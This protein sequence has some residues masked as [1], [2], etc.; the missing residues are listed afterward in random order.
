[1]PLRTRDHQYA[2]LKG[3]TGHYT[4]LDADVT[5]GLIVADC[6]QGNSPQ[7]LQAFGQ[8]FAAKGDRRI[9]FYTLL[10]AA[11]L[12]IQRDHPYRWHTTGDVKF[13]VLTDHP[14]N[15]LA[16]YLAH[17]NDALQSGHNK[18]MAP[19]PGRKDSF[20][21]R[22]AEFYDLYTGWTHGRQPQRE[23]TLTYIKNTP[24]ALHAWILLDV[25]Q[26][27]G[28]GNDVE[29]HRIAADV[30][31]RFGDQIGLVYASRYEHARSL[32]QA[33]ER[34]KAKKLFRE[35][36]A[37]ALKTGGL[38]L[39]D[40]HFSD[41]FRG[42]QASS[43]FADQM[44]QTC[45]DLLKRQQPGPGLLLAWQ[46]WQLGEQQL[47]DEVYGNAMALVGSNTSLMLVGIDYLWQTNQWARA[48]VLL[49]KVLQ[50]ERLAQRAA[51]WR[52][53]A[54]LAQRRGLTGRYVAYVEKGPEPAWRRRLRSG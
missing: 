54:A 40:Q 15:P 41:A 27:H 19:L 20:V 29:Y 22:L 49:Q 28:Q 36:Y 13:N 3:W 33:G 52:L 51:I 10:A 42:Q 9:G 43:D 48:D 1:M 6:L 35:L 18:E 47:A 39:I 2:Q 24:S 26:R 34:D 38:P 25:L 7:A 5:I 46:L 21:N 45:G 31:K 50:D 16:R 17:Y 53:G 11:P 4:D 32:L 37:D 23:R 44:R 8:R 14:K 30:H 12:F